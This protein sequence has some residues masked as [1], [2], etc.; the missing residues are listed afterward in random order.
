MIIQADISLTGQVTVWLGK[1]KGTWT[2]QNRNDI[3]VFWVVS[4]ELALLTFKSN[5]LVKAVHIQTALKYL[6]KMGGAKNH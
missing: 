6:L 2:E 1:T 4:S 5:K 3:A